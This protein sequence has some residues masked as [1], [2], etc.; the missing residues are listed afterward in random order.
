[1]KYLHKFTSMADFQAAYDGQDY[2]EPWV[3]L[4]LSGVPTKVSCSANETVYT[5]EY[6]GQALV[7]GETNCHI[8]YDGSNEAF[9]ATDSRTIE[10]GTE[11]SYLT[12]TDGEYDWND[13]SF[14]AE[15]VEVLESED[16]DYVHYNKKSIVEEYDIEIDCNGE[17]T[18]GGQ[19]ILSMSSNLGPYEAVEGYTYSVTNSNLTTNPLETIKVKITNTPSGYNIEGA[20]VECT[21]YNSEGN[22][23][24]QSESIADSE[25]FVEAHA[26]N[27]NGEWKFWVYLCGGC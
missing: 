1:M 22:H 11:I 15:D 5:L 18:C 7:G 21:H 10:E 2:I 12:V 3:S 26:N 14:S 6:Q 9:Y 20:V 8:W 23:I 19:E 27:N 4:T 17:Y 16:I 25:L 13:G 24:W